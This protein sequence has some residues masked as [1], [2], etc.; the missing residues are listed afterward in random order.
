M[1]VLQ[2]E[3]FRMFSRCIANH[4]WNIHATVIFPKEWIS[5]GHGEYREIPSEKD[6][7]AEVKDSKNTV[8]HFYKDSTF[9]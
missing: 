3:N 8:C 9:R 1:N 5:K 7:F 2:L 4:C 6:F